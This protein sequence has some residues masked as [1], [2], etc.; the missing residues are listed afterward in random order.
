MS[1]FWQWF[2]SIIGLVAFLM[3]FPFFLQLFFAQPK[4]GYS[5]SHDDAGKEG[6]IIKLHLMNIPVNNWLLKILRVAR[7]PVQ[8]LYLSIRVF[9]AS[10][11]QVISDIFMPKIELSPSDQSERVSLVA[12]LL[13][14]NVRLV[15]WQ[16][17]E[18]HATLISGDKLLPLKE[19]NYIFTM[20]VEYNGEEKISKP[21][22]LHI[23]KTEIEMDWD[24]NITGKIL[25]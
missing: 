14:A 21:F 4:I 6:R 15:K 16:R 8:D 5:F 11:G 1:E 20:A 17:S 24:E 9:D 18:N 12:S 2:F 22:L 13:N 19:G 23:G 3:A 25:V 10:D 7:L